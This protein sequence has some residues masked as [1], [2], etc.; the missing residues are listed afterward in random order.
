M[1][2]SNA[3]ELSK[4]C[5]SFALSFMLMKFSK[6]LVSLST[7]ANPFC[8][9]CSNLAEQAVSTVKELDLYPVLKA[10]MLQ[11]TSDAVIERTKAAAADVSIPS[12]HCHKQ[13]FHM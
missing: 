4:L 3:L 13:S 6:R 10:A 12:G 9:L 5:L 11:A 1:F 7:S 2:E 8:E